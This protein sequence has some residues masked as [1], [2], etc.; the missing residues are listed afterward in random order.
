MSAVE[1][2]WW[3]GGFFKRRQCWVPTLWGWL[4]LLGAI[5]LVCVGLVKGIYPFLAVHDPYRC[6]ILVV[7][8]WVPDYAMEELKVEFERGGYKLLVITGSP[9]LKGEALAEYKNF[10]DLTRAVLLKQGWDAE[11]VVAVPSGEVLRDRTYASARALRAWME[12]GGRKVECVNVLSR[13]AHCRR[14]R[15]LYQL[16]FGDTARVGI[17]SGVDQRYDGRVWW[18]SSEGVREIIDE[19]AAY[20]YAKFFFRPGGSKNS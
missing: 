1:G 11:K 5:G 3:S 2:K 17:I 19:S 15:L 7:E 20:I 4:V 12:G 16:A 13:A 10:A 18:K 8:G 6:E 14:T 9:I